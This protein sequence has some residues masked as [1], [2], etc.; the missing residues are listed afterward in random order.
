M[1]ILFGSSLPTC[2][3]CVS[4]G[5]VVFSVVPVQRIETVPVVASGQYSVDRRKFVNRG[6]LHVYI[7]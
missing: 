3:F 6:V 5:W 7:T 4:M 2:E 1:P